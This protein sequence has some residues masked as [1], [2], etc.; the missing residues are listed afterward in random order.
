MS[1]LRALLFDVDG[2]LAETE[3]DG[4]RVAFNQAFLEHGLPWHWS[5]RRYGELLAVTGGKER[6]AH[7]AAEEEPGWPGRADAA[8]AIAAIHASKNRRYQEL[9]ASGAIALRRG[10]RGLLTEARHA[11]LHLGVVTTTSRG[12]LEALL[13][14]ALDRESREAFALRI[15]GEDVRRKKP[16]PECYRLALQRLGL[17]PEQVL[18]V[19]D[20]R[21][22]LLSARAA[23]LQVLVVRSFYFEQ[24]DFD[25]ALQVA[26]EFIGLSVEELR[27]RFERHC[28]EGAQDEDA[29]RR[30]TSVSC[31]TQPG[32]APATLLVE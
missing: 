22:G 27:R 21:N 25:G 23:G 2:T 19:E 12:N 1:Q 16:D 20:S 8:A 11:G 24:D 17:R 28:R 32:V 6:I 13:A 5:E 30:H 3:R 7:F 26:D 9:V 14:A 29:V 31:A 18:A 10:L 4:H 15:A